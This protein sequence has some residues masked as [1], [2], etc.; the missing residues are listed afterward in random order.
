MTVAA[1]M[2]GLLPIMW[3]T[4]HRCRCHETDRG[5][6]DRGHGEL[7]GA[8]VVGDLRALCPL[9]WEVYVQRSSAPTHR[10][11]SFSAKAERDQRIREGKH[12]KEGE[13]LT[14]FGQ[15]VSF[16]SMLKVLLIGFLSFLL[17]CMVPLMGSIS[18]GGGHLHHDASVSCATCMGSMD[19]PLVIFLL[20]FLGSATFILLLFPPLVPSRSPFHPPRLS[21]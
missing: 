13:R 10:D 19:L 20:T 3:T 5:A 14:S 17:L 11:Q 1:I 18:N 16:I 7:D 8:D 15:R 9:A 2:G 4:G 6:D 12:M 21:S